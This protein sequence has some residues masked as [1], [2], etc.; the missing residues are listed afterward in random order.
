MA[1]K[2]FY[3]VFQG[4]QHGI[5]KDWVD[6]HKATNGHKGNVFKSFSSLEEAEQA[7]LAHKNVNKESPTTTTNQKD[8]K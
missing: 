3:V 6:Y 8:S 4:R 2:K 5:F 1:S 7:W